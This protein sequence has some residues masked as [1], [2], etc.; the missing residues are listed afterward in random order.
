MTQSRTASSVQRTL[1]LADYI[2]IPVADAGGD[3]EERIA[4]GGG[5]GE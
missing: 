2:P 5:N 3:E 4:E 1:T